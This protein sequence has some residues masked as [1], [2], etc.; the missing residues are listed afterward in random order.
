[1]LPYLLIGGIGV[2]AAVLAAI[3]NEQTEREREMQQKMREAHERVKEEYDQELERQKKQRAAA[4]GAVWDDE[5][6]KEAG[7]HIKWDAQRRN[8]IQEL[9]SVYRKLASEQL[10]DKIQLRKKIG[11]TKKECWDALH[12]QTS[13]LRR[14]SIEMLLR[15]LE[16]TKNRVYGYCVLLQK[17]IKYLDRFRGFEFP[18]EVPFRLPEDALYVGKLIK[19]EKRN[20]RQQGYLKPF[21]WLTQNYHFDEFDFLE[22]LGEDEAIPL[23]CTHFSGEPD[24]ALGLSA[25]KGQFIDAVNNLPRAGLTGRVVAGGSSGH[26]LLEY[27][28]A[29]KLRLPRSFLENPRR[30][31]PLGSRLTVYPLRWDPTLSREVTVSERAGDCFL[32][33][34]FDDIPISFTDAQWEELCAVLTGK[35][36]QDA[37]GEWKLAPLHEEELPNLEFMKFQLGNFLCFSAKVEKS[38]EKLFFAFEKMLGEDALIAPDDIFFVGQC[39]L[40]GFLE[41]DEGELPQETFDNMANLYFKAAAEFRIQRQIKNSTQGISYYNTWSQLT[42]K[43]KLLGC[44]GSSFFVRFTLVESRQ[45][46]D[47]FFYELSIHNYTELSAFR[48]KHA[49]QGSRPDFFVEL[50][51]CQPTPIEI[52]EDGKKARLF[53]REDM[54]AYFLE[55]STLRIYTKKFPV[56]EV[57]QLA[58][59]KNFREGRLVNRTLQ[60]YALDSAK[61]VSTTKNIPIPQFINTNICSDV[62]QQDAVRRALA[63]QDIFMIQG[64]PGTG[65]TTVIREIIAQELRKNPG[66][67]ILL[68]SQANV[69]VDN[70]LRN[71]IQ[72]NIRFVRCGNDQSIEPALTEHSFTKLHKEYVNALCS[73]LE[74]DPENALLKRWYKIIGDMGTTN[75]VLGG[76]LLRKYALIGATCVG[77]ANKNIGLDHEAFDLV[78]VDEAGKALPGELLIPYIR[79]RKVILIGDHKQLPPT[80]PVGLE[81]PEGCAQEDDADNS[82]LNISIFQRMFEASP[83]S[84]KTML[85]RQYRMPPVIGT[86]VSQM[87]YEGKILNGAGEKEKLPVIPYKNHN[88]G[89]DNLVFLNHSHV[90]ST[91]NA[92]ITNEYE[93]KLL[94]TVLEK[95]SSINK[96]ISIAVITPYKGQ[97]RLLKKGLERDFGNLRLKI[98]TVDGFQGDEA[99]LVFFCTTRTRTKTHFFSDVRRVNVA[100]SRAKRQLVIVGSL[101][102]FKSYGPSHILSKIAGYVEECGVVLNIQ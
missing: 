21:S 46:R 40:V 13:L 99:D 53:T 30:I 87:F 42:E 52:S 6:Q 25:R 22:T 91:D 81:L 1:M 77:L 11:A 47:D 54:A 45:T 102:Y 33:Y 48:Q 79:A 61:I 76:L 10:E 78:I 72:T 19:I 12:N 14:N 58:A 26:V 84:N 83:E 90:E 51:P 28:E 98:D 5:K 71:F 16:V 8:K 68:V 3:F 65:K 39:G 4:R 57:R 31:P 80:I 62:S 85:T 67:R 18:E 44:R 69:A 89:S 41:C 50:S 60:T 56:P 100:L 75:P 88:H 29:V 17:Y 23:L 27:N 97:K 7:E 35:G 86:L 96:T 36:A 101:T 82:S 34:D 73:K 49:E 92:S 37:I 32:A 2:G 24:F 94:H 9:V 74:N 95:T 93:I 15:E 20:I 38:G 55:G 59:L 70:V 64:P 63:E 66:Q 43:M